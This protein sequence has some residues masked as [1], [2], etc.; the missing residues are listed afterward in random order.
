MYDFYTQLTRIFNTGKS[1]SILLVGDVEDLFYDG[2]SFVPIVSFLSK[3]CQVK[4]TKNTKGVTQ[5][6]YETNRSVCVIGDENELRII[7]NQ[8]YGIYPPDIPDFKKE[9]A[10][11]A[12][13]KQTADNPTFALEFTRKLID[14]T[15]DSRKNNLLVIIE[16]ADMLLPESPIATM[17]WADR[18]RISIMKD[19]FSDP[20]FTNGHDSVVL[21]AESRSLVNGQVT[22]LPQ[23]LTI[24]VA[25][26]TQEHR[27]K[28]GEINGWLPLI[29]YPQILQQTAGLSIHAFRQVIIDPDVKIADVVGKVEDYIISLVGDEVVEFKR[30]THTLDD[31]VGYRDLKVFLKEKFIPSIA[32]PPE[33]SISGALF[34]GPLGSGK[35]YLAEAVASMLGIPVMVL[36][37]FRSQWFGQTDVLVERIKRAIYAIVKDSGGT[38]GGKLLLLIDEADTAF[39]NLSKDTHETERRATGKIQAL[40]SDP[41]LRGRAIWLLMTARPHLLSPDMRRP[42]RAGELIIP[43]L[44]PADHCEADLDDFIKWSVGNI[45]IPKEL[46]LQTITNWFSAADFQALKTRIAAEGCS[47]Y[48]GVVGLIHDTIPADIGKT[49]RYQKLQAVLNCTRRSLIPAGWEYEPD[50]WR[51]EI[52]KLESEAQGIQ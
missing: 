41:E 17:N 30:P 14:K 6:I 48:E 44:D 10:Y 42:G 27:R 40:M 46:A 37:N 50:A 25:N 12:L 49:R 18:K 26:P 15:R 38:E 31:C 52:R 45:K 20:R 35:T 2:T 7:W 8:A 29:R 5:I 34:A 16:G 28:F 36:K 9:N 24:N 33:K 47:D 21:I 51:E 13:I 23:L 3:R 1:H 11:D 43:I 19:W 32:G 39:G 22:R 4:P